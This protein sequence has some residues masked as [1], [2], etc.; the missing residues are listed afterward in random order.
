MPL[1]PRV[2]APAALRV[3]VAPEEPAA[4]EAPG[5]APASARSATAAG[6]RRRRTRPTA[7]TICIP[8][9]LGSGQCPPLDSDSALPRFFH[10]PTAVLHEQTDFFSVIK[11][12]EADV[13]G[14]L[15]DGAKL[16]IVVVSDGNPP[17]NLFDAG[18]ETR[19]DFR[20]RDPRISLF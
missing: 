7:H 13:W 15:R 1:A 14:R 9:P 18:T 6:A 11:A 16:S 2:R 12:N 4:P 10:H 5:G 17:R 20:D 3:G 8:P 19:F